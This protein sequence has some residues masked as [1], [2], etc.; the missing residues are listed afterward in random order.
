M[1][2]PQFSLKTLLW[3]IAVVAAFFAGA[4]W[5]YRTLVG[6]ARDVEAENDGLRET[7]TTYERLA[8]NLQAEA[9]RSNAA[10]Q[11][12]VE[13]TNKLQEAFYGDPAIVIRD[14]GQ[15]GMY[16]IDLEAGVESGAQ[17]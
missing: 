15:R 5:Q 16:Q 4:A 12:E 3:L 14:R 2:R 10:L 13:K 8:E 6:W 7:A 17:E 1:P 9:S 11:R